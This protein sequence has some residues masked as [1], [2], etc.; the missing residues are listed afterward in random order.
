MRARLPL[1]ML[2][3][4]LAQNSQAME[5]SRCGDQLILSGGIER[6]DIFRI[7]DAITQ[8]QGIHTA[9]LRNSPG[10]N[11]DAGYQIGEYFREHDIST[12]AS[13]FCLSSCSR[14]FLGG[15]ERFF[16]NDY[17]PSQTVV[18]FHSNYT[19]A[20]QIAPG[21]QWK[22]KQYIN[23]YS[24]GK[25][26]PQLVERWVNIPYRNGFARFFHP[27]A[28]HRSDKVSILL[29][30]GHEPSLQRWRQCEH[31]SGHDALSMG[32][33][34]STE[35]KRSCDADQLVA[36]PSASEPATSAAPNGEPTRP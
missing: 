21:A 15:A 14:M 8:D 18:G 12:Y 23:K 28:L 35:I 9:V 2:L 27:S 1:I 30:T 29:C 25:A 32:I 31:I 6:E 26:D 11:A 33:I 5:M 22:L 13:G 20:G 3:C 17:P 19:N 7:K 4:G 16:T 36:T 10:G 34:T 24:D